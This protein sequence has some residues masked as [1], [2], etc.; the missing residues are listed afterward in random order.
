MEYCTNISELKVKL[1]ENKGLTAGENEFFELKTMI[2]RE[3]I[4]P[5]EL[6]ELKDAIK[7][8]RYL[9]KSQLRNLFISSI[10]SKNL[11]LI[12]IF[13]DT[14]YIQYTDSDVILKKAIETNNLEIVEFLLSKGLNP[15]AVFNFR[16]S[17]VNVMYFAFPNREMI[18]LFQS[19]GGTLRNTKAILNRARTPEEMKLAKTLLEGRI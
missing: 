18:E 5:A 19:Y 1:K 10:S 17:Y 11:T 9:D 3:K 12:K 14:S 15:N 6:S 13:F 7:S 8:S 16:N 2:L 4:T